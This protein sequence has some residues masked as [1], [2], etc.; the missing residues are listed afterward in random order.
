MKVKIQNI[1]LMNAFIN[2]I[3]IEVS[4][5]CSLSTKDTFSLAISHGDYNSKW[6]MENKNR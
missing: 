4:A 1:T 2:A 5:H 3:N 6:Q